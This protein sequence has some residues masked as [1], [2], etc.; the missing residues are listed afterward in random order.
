MYKSGHWNTGEHNK[1]PRGAGALGSHRR[2]FF[3]T[4]SSDAEKVLPAAFG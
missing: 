3:I 1:H 4:A 2:C